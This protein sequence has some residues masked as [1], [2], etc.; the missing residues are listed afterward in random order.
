MTSTISGARQNVFARR[1]QRVVEQHDHR[2]AL[3]N[4]LARGLRF[5][6]NLFLL[7]GLRP[8]VFAAGQLPLLKIDLLVLQRMGEFVRQYRL[9]NVRLHPVQEIDALRLGIV[10]GC[11]LLA[12]QAKKLR[13]QV[14]A[15][16]KQAEFLQHQPG[17]LQPLR[18]L[19]VLHAL[20]NVLLHRLAGDEV[21]LDLVLDR[22]AGVVAGELQDFI[23]RTEEF[24]GLRLGDA[25]L[26]L[27]LLD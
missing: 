17:L 9:L 14:V 11:N 13:V 2:L 1:G 25:S 26:W 24:L 15:R 8:V 4:T 22:Q 19:I 6:H 12:Q 16:R 27:R 3:G 21:T 20:V 7:V 5:L 18:V 23:D 10:V